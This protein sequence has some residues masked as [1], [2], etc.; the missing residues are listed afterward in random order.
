M[1]SKTPVYKGMVVLDPKIINNNGSTDENGTA[2]CT[3]GYPH[4]IDNMTTNFSL[5]A[6]GVE[7][8]H[9]WLQRGQF[10]QRLI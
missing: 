6:G 3:E 5:T 9:F 7:N 1:I 4:D 8:C 2:T 10:P